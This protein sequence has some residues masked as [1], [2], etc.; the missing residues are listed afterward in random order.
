MPDVGGG[1]DDQGVGAEFLGGGGE[2]PGRA[3]AAGADVHVELGVAGDLVE[4]GA[5]GEG[6]AQ[7]SI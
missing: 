2:F 4:L 6:L 5:L 7:P 1:A 3:A